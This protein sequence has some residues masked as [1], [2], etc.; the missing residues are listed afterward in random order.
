MA[1]FYESQWFSLFNIWWC[2]ETSKRKIETMAAFF[3]NNLNA[4]GKKKFMELINQ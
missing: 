4:E 2:N 3:K 1:K